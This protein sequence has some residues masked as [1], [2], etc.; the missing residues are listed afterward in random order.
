MTQIHYKILIFCLIMCAILPVSSQIHTSKAISTGKNS[1]YISSGQDLTFYLKENSPVKINTIFYP[2]LT[3][4]VEI[5]TENPAY[6]I[7]M[8]LISPDGKKYFTNSDKNYIKFWHFCFQS[9]S[10]SIIELRARNKNIKEQQV[11]IKISYIQQ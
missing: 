4:K 8:K 10:S 7:E 2:Q 6:D 5:I 1:T 3:Y 9:I 11:Q